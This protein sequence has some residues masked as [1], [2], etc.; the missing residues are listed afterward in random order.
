MAQQFSVM[1]VIR[2]SD[3]SIRWMEIREYLRRKS[4]G[5]KKRVRQIAFEGERFDVLSVRRWRDRE[6]RQASQ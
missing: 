4:D 6:L 2:T 1:L 5:G 3:G